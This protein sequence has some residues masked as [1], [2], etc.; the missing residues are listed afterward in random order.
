MIF[1]ILEKQFWYFND[2]KEFTIERFS[3]QLS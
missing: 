2:G 1:F 3:Y